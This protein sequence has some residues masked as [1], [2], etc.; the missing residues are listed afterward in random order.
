MLNETLEMLEEQYLLLLAS[1]KPYNR[2]FIMHDGCLPDSLQPGL[3]MP[4]LAPVGMVAGL[5]V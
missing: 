3:V 1:L 4:T 2:V 5:R